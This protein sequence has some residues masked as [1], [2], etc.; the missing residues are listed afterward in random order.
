MET[1]V[2]AKMGFITKI[3]INFFLNRWRGSVY[4]LVWRELF[5]YLVIYY[6]INMF[7]HY[8]LTH[9]QRM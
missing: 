9:E 1:C 5:F 7:Y 3:L 4:K 8:G 2:S 6:S